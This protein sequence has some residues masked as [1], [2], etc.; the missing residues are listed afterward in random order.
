MR[1]GEP[2]HE[3]AKAPA[4]WSFWD[5]FVKRLVVILFSRSRHFGRF[6]HDKVLL[7]QWHAKLLDFPGGP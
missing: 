2:I 4:V 3:L 5:S 7:V 6:L 1:E